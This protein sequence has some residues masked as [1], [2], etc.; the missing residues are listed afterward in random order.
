MTAS[1]ATRAAPTKLKDSSSKLVPVKDTPKSHPTKP[2]RHTPPTAAAITAQLLQQKYAQELA[3]VLKSQYP[4]WLQLIEKQVKQQQAAKA[5]ALAEA[6]KPIDNSTDKVDDADKNKTVVAVDDV[7]SETTET[8]TI[9]PL[10]PKTPAP[11]RTR[12]SSTAHDSTPPPPRKRKPRTPKPKQDVKP[13][14]DVKTTE[15][16]SNDDVESS[17]L[18]SDLDPAVLQ[19]PSPSSHQI[20]HAAAAIRIQSMIDAQVPRTLRRD[21]FFSLPL[22]QEDSQ[23]MKEAIPEDSPPVTPRRSISPSL[24]SDTGSSDDHVD[25]DFDVLSPL[26]GFLD[27]HVDLTTEI[28]SPYSLDDDGI[29]P[30]QAP[31]VKSQSDALYPLA[32]PFELDTTLFEPVVISPLQLETVSTVSTK[33][34]SIDDVVKTSNKRVRVV[35]PDDE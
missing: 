5:A 32:P 25:D 27:E 4:E 10:K 31:I 33:K 7:K 16:V 21:C 15:T 22:N 17:L 13:Q 9:T 2:P 14:E 20:A 26:A 18:F 30:I 3:K 19:T 23:D 28:L 34:R 1:K 12:K 6:D 24:V 35:A 8:K 11:K 29:Q